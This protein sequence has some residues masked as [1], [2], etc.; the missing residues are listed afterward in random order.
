VTYVS[1]LKGSN[2]LGNIGVDGK[3]VSVLVDRVMKLGVV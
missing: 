3:M 2:N 1:Y